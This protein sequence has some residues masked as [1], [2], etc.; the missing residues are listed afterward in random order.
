MKNKLM[1]SESGIIRILDI[2]EDKVL[3]IDCLKKTMPV[4]VDKALLNNYE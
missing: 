2:N 1:K 4:W 3:V